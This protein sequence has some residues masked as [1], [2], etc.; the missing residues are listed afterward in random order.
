MGSMT[1]KIGHFSS[2]FGFSGP[3]EGP[4]LSLRGLWPPDLT[5]QRVTEAVGPGCAPLSGLR[6]P[7]RPGRTP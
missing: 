3:S 4:I 6:F 2:F 1:L 7:T 5:P